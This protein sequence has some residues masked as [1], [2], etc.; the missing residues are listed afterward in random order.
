MTWDVQDRP[1]PGDGGDSDLDAR[2]FDTWEAAAAAMASR[3]D[4]PAGKEALLARAGLRAT[5]LAPEGTADLGARSG[6]TCP[7]GQRQT[8]R[9]RRRRPSPRRPAL[10]WAAGMAGLLAAGTVA[11]VAVVVP[12]SGRDGTPAPVINTAY[13]MKRMNGALSAAAPAAIAQM[14]VTTRGPGGTTTGEVWSYGD[15]SR[16]VTNSAAGQPAYDQ[17]LS[18]SGL[19]YTVVSYQMR[20]WGRH[21]RPDGLLLSPRGCDPGA[22]IVPLP[23]PAGRF[24]GN[25]LPA[26]VVSALRAAISCGTLTVAGRQRI[27]GIEA[28]KLASRGARPPAESIWVSPDTY[29]PVRVTGSTRTGRGV[30]RMTAD[31]A[32]LRPTAPNLARLTVPIPA[33]FRQVSALLIL[34]RMRERT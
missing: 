2:L 32:W 19:V 25:V 5:P 21:H 11:L 9:W 26:T 10:R 8:G 1:G 28:I 17:G 14:V 20:A 24:A 22:A 7:A 31:I 15:Q 30:F 27:D 3:L 12:G 23:G 4:L 16:S 34:M 29:L 13:V 6:P 18:G 33:G